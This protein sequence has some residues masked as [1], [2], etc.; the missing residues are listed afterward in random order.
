MHKA[1]FQLRRFRDAL[2]TQFMDAPWAKT[3]NKVELRTYSGFT[4]IISMDP[5]TG[6]FGCIVE[7]EPKEEHLRALRRADDLSDN[8]LLPLL[9]TCRSKLVED[10]MRHDGIERRR[11]FD[12]HNYREA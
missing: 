2:M 9:A 10:V 5:K 6:E 11:A 7:G 3:T 1:N 8:Q 12:G 4:V